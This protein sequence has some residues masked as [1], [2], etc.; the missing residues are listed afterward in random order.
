MLRSQ[1]QVVTGSVRVILK[2]VFTI[3]QY[4]LSVPA[5]RALYRVKGKSS[6]SKA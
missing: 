5:A 4:C 3:G 2:S 1:L 6:I